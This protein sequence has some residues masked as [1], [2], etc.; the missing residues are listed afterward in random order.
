LLKHQLVEDGEGLL[1]MVTKMTESN[2]TLQENT[3]FLQNDLSNR[4]DAIFE[5]EREILLLVQKRYKQLL[6]K[7]VSSFQIQMKSLMQAKEDITFFTSSAMAG[8]MIIS[9]SRSNLFF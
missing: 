5:S 6:D 8:I 3:E 4:T 2:R 1:N 9:L 7:A